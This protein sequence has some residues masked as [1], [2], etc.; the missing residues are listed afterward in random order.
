[1]PSRA[2]LLLQRVAARKIRLITYISSRDAEADAR[3]V[4]PGQQRVLGIRADPALAGIQPMTGPVQRLV[5]PADLKSFHNSAFTR[6]WLSVAAQAAQKYTK[7]PLEI[8]GP[9]AGDMVLPSTARHMGW[10]PSLAH[11]YDGNTAVLITNVAGSGVPNKF[12]EA[13]AA[14]RPIIAHESLDYVDRTGNSPVHWF[15]DIDQLDEAV[16]AAVN[17]EEGDRSERAGAGG[18]ACPSLSLSDF[19]V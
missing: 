13:Q 8:Y 4:G 16:R 7:R 1:M 14:R 10:A 11:I 2:G 17:G 6:A 18:A 12:V 3:L 9:N 15:A 5:V 19:P